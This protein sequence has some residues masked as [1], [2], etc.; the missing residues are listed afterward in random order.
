MRNERTPHNGAPVQRRAP[1]L[2]RRVRV[3]ARSQQR[4]CERVP[5]AHGGAM[6]RRL[7][8]PI[9]LIHVRA[10]PARAVQQRRHARRVVAAHRLMQRPF[11]APRRHAQG[12][13][14]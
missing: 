8:Q 2:V 1:A 14:P 13:V 10:R 6:Q 9:A 12:S 11:H 5:A 4:A 3:R 7:L